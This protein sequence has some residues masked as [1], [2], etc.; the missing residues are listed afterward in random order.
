MD[1]VD[2]LVEGRGGGVDVDAFSVPLG[3]SWWRQGQG[4]RRKEV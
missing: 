1:H 3:E 4:Q 2:A